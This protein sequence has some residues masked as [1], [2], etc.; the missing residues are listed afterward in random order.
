MA[1]HAEP[2]ARLDSGHRQL[3]R[4]LRDQAKDR[5]QLVVETGWSRNTV[6]ARL[7]DLENQGWLARR[8]APR[9]ERGRPSNLYELNPNGRFFFIVRFG[10]DALMGVISTLRGK[11]LGEARSA[12]PHGFTAEGTVREIETMLA[13]L[14]AETGIDRS[15][16]AA[17]VLGVPGPVH[18]RSRTVPWSKV[19]VLP[20]NL[21]EIMGMEVLIENDANLMALGAR[22]QARPDESLLY[23]FIDIGIGAGLALS[24]ELHRGAQ[25]WAGEIG[26]I[27]VAAA[28]G[29]PCVCGSEGCVA[30]VAS[31]P[32]LV[33]QVSTVARPVADPL[34][35]A[36]LVEHGD[37]EAIIALRE[38][39]RNLGEALTGPV[40]A[41]APDVVMVGGVLGRAGGH[42][43]AGIRESLTRRMPP[44][45]AALLRIEDGPLEEIAAIRGAADLGF[46]LLF[47]EDPVI[48]S[49][50]RLQG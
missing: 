6:A 39:G 31:N 35:L 28:A 9:A 30:A 49:G 38:A 42:L 46:D 34:A 18:G 5:A 15:C 8:D 32:A 11:V 21:A 24:G 22:L 43:Q 14:V 33:R 3:A 37:L 25:G 29:M 20:E 26:H 4:A 1:K 17:L 10:P 7:Q 12:L 50:L 48:P 16:I 44:A 13:R 41:L 47:G 19:G 40:I 27:P 2:L 23:V 36:K 45:L